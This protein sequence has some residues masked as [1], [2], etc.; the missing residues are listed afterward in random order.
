MRQ[1]LLVFFIFIF[2]C[3]YPTRKGEVSFFSD[4]SGAEI[5]I[6]GKPTGKFTP[7]KINLNL[8]YGKRKIEFIKK[9]YQKETR[10]VHL[11]N[12]LGFS[13]ISTGATLDDPVLLPFWWTWDDVLLPIKFETGLYPNKIFVRLEKEN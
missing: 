6:D 3:V 10:V 11:K 5:Y 1:Y 7:C 13:R 12:S 9:G 4:P 2:G 8:L